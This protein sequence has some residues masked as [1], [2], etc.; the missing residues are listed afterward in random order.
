MNRLIAAALMLVCAVVLPAAARAQKAR[1][2]LDHV[3]IVVTPGAAAE[4]AALRAAGLT[5]VSEPMQ[6][7]GQG[8]ASVAAYFDNAYLELIWVDSTVAIDADHAS[9]AHWFRQA[10]AWRAN[11]RSPFGLGLHRLPGDTAPLPVSVKREPAPW[12][13]AGNAYE[14]LHQPADSLAS[15]FFVVPALTAVPSWVAR[16]RQ[17]KPELWQHAGGGG[18]ITLLRVHGPPAH[19][20]LAFQVLRPPPVEMVHAQDPLLEI[21]INR[22]VRGQR[23]DLRPALPLVLVR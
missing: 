17:R 3:F 20:P 11:G 15:D 7:D 10:S 22:G 18:A 8:T 16:A 19:E 5:V 4:I 9:T 21:H 1:V 12:L 13:P 14:L 23:V 2:E 6:H